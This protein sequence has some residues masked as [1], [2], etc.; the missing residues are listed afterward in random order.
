MIYFSY[1]CV[2]QSPHR[3]L[4]KGTSDVT[5]GA[6]PVAARAGAQLL[7]LSAATA[8]RPVLGFPGLNLSGP[9]DQFF[10]DVKYI[11]AFI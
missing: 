5:V 9:W 3:A 4:I 8:G 7:W 2:S 11:E 10:N 1:Q 6:A